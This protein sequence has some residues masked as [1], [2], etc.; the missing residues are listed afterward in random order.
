MPLSFTDSNTARMMRTLILAIGIV[1]LASACSPAQ[2]T[3][4]TA[5]NA[6]ASAVEDQ[7]AAAA[8]SAE[9]PADV[10]QQLLAHSLYYLGETAEN[11]YQIWKVDAMGENFTQLTDEPVTVSEFDVSANDGKVAYLSNNQ[12]IVMNADG[13]GRTVLIDGSSA[14]QN[15][16]EYFFREQFGGLSWS[17]DGSILAYGQNGLHLYEMNS[18]SDA[19]IIKNEVE[20]S[21]SGL[22]IPTS[23]YRPLAWSPDGSRLL[24]DIGFYEAGTLGV[25]DL[26]SQTVTR[27]GDGIVCCHPAWSADS[28]SVLVASPFLGIVSPGLWRYDLPDGNQTVLIPDTTPD[29]TLNFA[30]WPLV[31][32]DGNLQFF[33][34]NMPDFPNGDVSMLMVR[35]GPDGEQERT[36]LRSDALDNYEVLWAG[37]GSQAVAVQPATGEAA[38]FPRTGPI[39]VIPADGETPIAPL[40][41]SGYQLRWGP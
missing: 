23:L 27:L 22:L 34:A 3:N 19:H 30:G 8:E 12:L 16:D 28:Q 1:L 33:F 32:P 36:L 6:A 31:L 14:E 29:D 35:T 38:G 9:P 4:H 41:V 25:Y 40:G 21:G 10:P 7:P 5:N 20:D 13:S 39:V 17:P 2:P 11:V 37:D 18:G 24:V 26:E 15:T